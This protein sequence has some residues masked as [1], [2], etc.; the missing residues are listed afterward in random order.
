MPAPYVLVPAGTFDGAGAG[1]RVAL[2]PDAAHHLT[3]VLRLRDGAHVVAA[4]GAGTAAPGQV[5]GD[6]IRLGEPPT[7]TPATRP[8]VVVW[9][10]LGKGRKHDE[11]VRVATELGVD[12]IVAVE[13]DRTVVELGGKVDR[14][15]ARWRA[16]A[17]AACEQA[18]RPRLP[19]LAGPA[20][21]ADLLAGLDGRPCLV[22]HV[23]EATEPLAAARDVLAEEP[24]EV[25]VAVGPEGGWTAEEVAA[26]TAA[27]AR[28]V[29]LGPTVLRTEH[30]ATVL[31]TVVLAAAGRLAG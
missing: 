6:G 21:V 19:E 26:F 5:A 28:V 14:V 18:R 9:Q 31:A 13:T 4:D 11:V 22:A 1:D 29:A 23:G 15:H 16:V 20:A 2:P 12:G 8:R 3:R 7:T 10:G 17:T 27:G 24:A 30:A 25:V